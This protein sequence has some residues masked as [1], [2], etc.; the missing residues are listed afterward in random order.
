MHPGFNCS[1]KWNFLHQKNGISFTNSSCK[2]PWSGD[3]FFL[4]NLEGFLFS[5][6]N[7]WVLR[8]GVME[9]PHLQVTSF[10]A[11]SQCSTHCIN[12]C[13]K[14]KVATETCVIKFA[15]CGFWFC[16]LFTQKK[17]QCKFP[18]SYHF[19]LSISMIING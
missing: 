2:E 9:S 3:I 14:P 13:A 19:H 6:L 7:C 15:F 10:C 18:Y 11:A 8:R 16:P 17:E 4:E 12:P 5:G 1:Q